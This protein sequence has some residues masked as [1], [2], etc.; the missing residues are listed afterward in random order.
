MAATHSNTHT[1]PFDTQIDRHED[2]LRSCLRAVDALDRLPG[3]TSNAKWTAFMAR[4]VGVCAVFERVA[5]LRP[6]VISN[7]CGGGRRS[8]RRQPFVMN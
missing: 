6:A 5:R 7:S 1:P 8:K 4:T 3:A 2:S